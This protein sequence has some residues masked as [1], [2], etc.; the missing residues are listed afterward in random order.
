MSIIWNS[1]KVAEGLAITQSAR[2]GLAGSLKE[3][4]DDYHGVER[5]GSYY[6]LIAGNWLDKFLHMT[7]V[8]WQNVLSG[9]LLRDRYPVRV[10]DDLRTFV[11]FTIDPNF[12]NYWQSIVQRLLVG[13]SHSHR[14]AGGQEVRFPP[15]STLLP[16]L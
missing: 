6:D 10:S 12:H 7:Y 4:L 5:S 13:E 3:L 9:G 8:A 1:V 14:H 2:A 16:A 11:L 15:S